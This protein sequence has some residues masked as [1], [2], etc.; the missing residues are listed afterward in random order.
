MSLLDQCISNDQIL[1]SNLAATTAYFLD[2][3]FPFTPKPLLKSK[4]NQI[5]A[6]L[7][8]PLT[9]ENAEAAL[10]RSTIGALE[11][12]LLAQDVHRG[13]PRA[14]FLLKSILALL[15]TSLTRDQK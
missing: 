6:K 13:I 1:D 11:S 7:A 2:L 9:L 15:E 10:V 8:Q 3:V 14:R 5:L 12:L 4:F